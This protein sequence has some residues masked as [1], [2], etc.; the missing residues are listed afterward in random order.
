MKTTNNTLDQSVI[1]H[2]IGTA[3]PIVSKILAEAF[4]IPQ[5]IIL[6]LLYN[7]PSVLFHQVSQEL[8]KQAEDL[9][10]N[11]GLEVKVQDTT[12]AL[13]KTQEQYDVSVYLNRPA[14]LPIVSTQLSE[15]LGC[16]TKAALNLLFQEPSIVLGGISK[17]TAVALSKRLDAEV[18]YS[19]P[20]K[21]LYNLKIETTDT[22]VLTQL[23]KI[24]QS[25]FPSFQI[26]KKT[27]ISDLNY[28]TS[29]KIWQAFHTQSGIKIINQSHQRYEIILN[30]V[31]GNTYRPTLIDEVGMPDFIIDKV[32]QHLP[33]QLEE[34]LCF[35]VAQAKVE[36]FKSVGLDCT[37]APLPYTKHQI[38]IDHITNL[39]ATRQVLSQFLETKDLPTQIGAWLAPAGMNDLLTR[40]ILTQLEA[41]GCTAKSQEYEPRNNTK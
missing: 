22:A 39:E 5:E 34:S 6:K 10:A 40:Y 20:K 37:Y 31:S 12:V 16:S 29:Q 30:K 36:Q 14:M 27:S 35:E 3:N 2:S 38:Q 15:F 4:K 24:V 25:Q 33:V 17:A 23:Q 8:A 26:Q 41:I 21:D 13:P 32:L 9:L 19:N 1:I 11:L 18:V 7:A 28:L